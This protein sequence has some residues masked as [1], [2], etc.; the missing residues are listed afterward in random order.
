MK[1]AQQ[2]CAERAHAL[3]TVT[4]RLNSNERIGYKTLDM[5][6]ARTSG[7]FFQPP[8]AVS[9]KIANVRDNRLAAVAAAK[10]WRSP[11]CPPPRRPRTAIVAACTQAIWTTIAHS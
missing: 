6:E 5:L 11:P 2:S 1:C 3:L 10:T 4:L 9:T 8:R 7:S